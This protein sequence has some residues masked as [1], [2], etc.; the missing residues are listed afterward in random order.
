MSL[1]AEGVEASDVVRGTTVTGSDGSLLGVSMPTEGDGRRPFSIGEPRRYVPM[2]AVVVAA[3]GAFLAFLDSTVVNVAFPDIQSAFPHTGVTTLSWILNAYNVV[4]AGLLVLAGRFADLLG[5]RRLFAVGLAIFTVMSGL[6]A[7]ATSVQMLIVF[8]ALQAVG[9]ALLVPASL[10]IVV[11]ASTAEGRTKALTLWAAAAALAAGIGPPIGG[12]LVDLYNWRLVFLINV[13]LGLVALFM[14]RRMVV[15]SRAPGLRIMPDLR[16]ALLLSLGLGAVTLGIVQG[17]NWGWTSPA[18][19]ATFIVAAVSVALTVVSSARHRSPVLDPELLRIRGFTVSNLIAVAAGLGLYT[20]LLAHILWLH[21][22]W[23][24]SLLN[25]GLAVAPGAVVA[26][27]VSLPAS[28]L[29]ERFGP[30]AVVV[31]GAL[32]WS[33]AYVWY[34]T[35]VGIQ[36]DFLGEWLPGQILSGIGVGATLSIAS[37]GGLATVPAGR[38][39]TASAFNASVRQLGGVLGIALLTVFISHATLAT[40]AEAI[41]RGWELAAASFAVVAVLALFFGRIRESGEDLDLS[42]GSLRLDT[43]DAQATLTSVENANDFLDLLPASVRTDVLAS[44]DEIELAAGSILFRA[45]DAGDSMYVLVAGRLALEH[46]DGSVLDVY[47]E[48]TLGELALLTEAPRSATVIAR[49]DST[50]VKVSR[51]RFTELTSSDPAVMAAMA[52]GVAFRLQNSRPLLPTTSPAPKVIAVIALTV[53]APVDAVAGSLAASLSARLRV[54]TM[55]EARPQELQR[56]EAGHDRVL[57]VAGVDGS[58]AAS[59]RRQ[60]DRVV[61]VSDDPMPSGASHPEAPCDVVLTGAAPTSAQILRWHDEVGCRRV[62]H[63]GTDRRGWPERLRELHARLAGQSVGLVLAGGGARSLAH[64]GV[65]HAF[66]DAGITVDRVAGSSMGALVAALYAT[67]ATADE[68]DDRVFDEFV[69]RRPFGDFRPSLTSLAKGERG[70]AMLRR[71]F[72]DSRLEE[73]ARELVVVSTDLYERV[74][75]YYRRGSTAEVVGASMCVPVLF[76][77]RR[78]GDRTLVD[79]TLTDNCPVGPLCEHPEGPVVAVHFENAAS[80][81]DDDPP[82]LGETL[83]LVMQ[84]GDRRAE[85]NPS[86]ATVTVVPDTTGIG[87]LEFHQIDHAREAGREA[88]EAAVAALRQSGLLSHDAPGPPSVQR[89]SQLIT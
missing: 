6:C 60:A 47:P 87:L 84:M 13:P 32:V 62:Y 83:L 51:Q 68:V 21:Y 25:S 15:E 31:P 70:N 45:G 46:P 34:A 75:V 37:A 76:P 64:I 79:G 78:I 16:G 77:P 8:R 48:A 35:R 33:G 17:G 65:L 88:G 57:L 41:R 53:G 23:Q 43:S 2:A 81:A 40:F 1:A 59:C 39:A 11:H 5:R 85:G 28:R 19:L 14:T 22:I 73:L 12:A 86:K 63:A 42:S 4:F 55:A 36:P 71:C 9:A 80:R 58:W 29:A 26:A 24:Y 49:R 10:G 50:L 44:G 67:G 7:L 27:I 56:A 20:Y 61:L 30:R 74:P 18:I 54:T 38:Y 69:R 3:C 89:E 66:E 52:R 72:G 82:S